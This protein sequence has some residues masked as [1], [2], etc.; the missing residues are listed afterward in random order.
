MPTAI[1]KLHCV[2]RSVFQFQRHAS[3]V[4]R[5]DR[6]APM[7]GSHPVSGGM[8]DATEPANPIFVNIT[9]TTSRVVIVGFQRNMVGCVV[10]GY[11]IKQLAIFRFEMIP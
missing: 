4:L 3:D 1:Y 2:A 9:P 7:C 5:I 6:M 8:A 10:F 11:Q